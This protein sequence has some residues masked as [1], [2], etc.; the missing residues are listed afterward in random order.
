[1]SEHLDQVAALGERILHHLHD[2][3]LRGAGHAD[4]LELARRLETD[5]PLI[6]AACRR[7]IAQGQLDLMSDR[8]AGEFLVRITPEGMRADEERRS[9]APAPAPSLTQNFHAPVGTVAT[10]QGPNASITVQHHAGITTGELAALFE[11]LRLQAR[12]LPEEDQNEAQDTIAGLEKG[13]RGGQLGRAQRALETLSK[14]GGSTASF[15]TALTQIAKALGLH[16]P[17]GDA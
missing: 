13:W 15:V 9:P 7:L 16:L 3:R 2:D 17:G 1:M 14:L 4:T 8:G 6:T 11:H 10:Q 5:L 12:T